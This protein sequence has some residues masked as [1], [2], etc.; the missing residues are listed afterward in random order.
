MPVAESATHAPTQKAPPD[1]ALIA[2]WR[3]LLDFDNKSTSEKMDYQRIRMWVL[4]L[5][6][7]SSA[8]AV[9]SAFP[10]GD[11]LHFLF[12]VALVMLPVASVALMNFAREYA[13]STDWIE[14]RVTAELIRTQIYLY[15]MEAGEYTQKDTQSQQKLLLGKI[16]SYHCHYKTPFRKVCSL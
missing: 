9:V 10:V 16:S 7:L 8:L 15:R 12:R 3:R 4:W 5:S 11:L 1:P 14:Y 13:T 2:A 6:F